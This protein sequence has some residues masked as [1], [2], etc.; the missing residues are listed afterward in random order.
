MRWW[1]TVAIVGVLFAM[2]YVLCVVAWAPFHELRAYWY[3]D[4]VVVRTG[5]GGP[6]I[7]T[8]VYADLGEASVMGR[9][10]IPAAVGGCAPHKVLLS[11]QRDI[12]WL[13]YDGGPAA[14]PRPG[15]RILA[16]YADLHMTRE[17]D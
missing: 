8:H 14:P 1:I 5:V 7:V 3:D 11:A 9:L 6:F 2:F 15:T 4:R 17:S 12:V 16:L 10:R 13:K